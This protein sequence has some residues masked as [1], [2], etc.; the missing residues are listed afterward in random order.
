MIESGAL[1]GSWFLAKNPNWVLKIKEP[2]RLLNLRWSESME[3][4]CTSL[5]LLAVA[6]VTRK[7]VLT[8][9]W[10]NEALSNGSNGALHICDKTKA[11]SH[12][13]AR[14]RSTGLCFAKDFISSERTG[15][16][17]KSY[18]V[19]YF[20]VFEIV[21]LYP[22]IVLTW[23]FFTENRNVKKSATIWEVAW[24]GSIFRWFAQSRKICHFA[25]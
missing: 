17:P 10:N 18:P 7:T 21:D 2:S 8:D 9:K 25:S 24:I 20:K 12:L 22:L 19:L 11:K 16:D 4:A 5:T 14:D 3:N 15:C 13:G 23:H 1:E 6:R